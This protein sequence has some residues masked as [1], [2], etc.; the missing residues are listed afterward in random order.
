AVAP[1]PMPSAP[2]LPYP[3]ERPRRSTRKKG[4]AIWPFLVGGGVLLAGG[5]ALA[6]WL[7]MGGGG[8][9]TEDLA[10]VSADAQVFVS[11]KV[12]DFWESPT[13][14]DARDALPQKIK[15]QIA[16]GEKRSNM[17]IS[18]MERFTLV[19]LD[20]DKQQMY[21]TFASSKLIDRKKS[22]Q[23]IEQQGGSK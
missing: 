23:D 5:V 7:L 22:L 15:D 19:G 18:D 4:M 8:G 13:M 16:Q 12:A 3:G 1:P 9:S 10:L 20:M 6:V 17:K 11:V 21:M 14:K 2:P